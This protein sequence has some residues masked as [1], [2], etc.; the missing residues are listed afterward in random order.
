MIFFVIYFFAIFI[1]K[2][3]KQNKNI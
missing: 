3:V 1:K 2:H